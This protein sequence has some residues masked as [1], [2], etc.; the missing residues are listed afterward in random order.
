MVLKLPKSNIQRTPLTD[1]NVDYQS[2]L[3]IDRALLDKVTMQPYERVLCGNMSH[4]ER[5]ETYTIPGE[6]DSRSIILNGATAPL[7]K[8]DDFLTIMSFPSVTESEAIDWR[9]K[10]IVLGTNYATIA[11]RWAF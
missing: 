3:I 10:V 9:P 2:N 1:A 4:G 8:K 11:T 6:R 7:G 5:F